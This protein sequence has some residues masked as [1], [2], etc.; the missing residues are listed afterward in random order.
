MSKRFDEEEEDPS[1]RSKYNRETTTVAEELEESGVIS[2][3]N[4]EVSIQKNAT[5]F[6]ATFT[7]K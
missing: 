7:G 5:L 3:Q 2:R 1:P 6:A 4:E